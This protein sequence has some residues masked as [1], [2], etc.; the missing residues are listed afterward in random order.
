M[1][2]PV[3]ETERTT[4]APG[5]PITATRMLEMSPAELD[6]LFGSSP[7]GPIPVGRGAGTVIALPGTEV[8]KPIATVL[9]VLCWQGKVFDPQTRDLRNLISP[10][11]I[12]AVRAE[13]SASQSWVDGGDCVLLDYSR[14]SRVAGWIRDEI[15][16]VAPGVYLGVVWGVGKVFGGR[17]RVLRFALTFPSE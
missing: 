6:A 8:A 4:T 3:D 7:A 5:P 1:A 10:F 13:V 14:S 17:K 12:P 9:R 11:G 16:E 2:L 15:R